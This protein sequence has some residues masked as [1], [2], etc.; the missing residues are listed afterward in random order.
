MQIEAWG[1]F[2]EGRNNLFQN[3]ALRS[4]ADKHGR[5]IAQ[6]VLHW[7]IHRGIVAI[8]ESVRRERMAENLNIF[9]FELDAEDD[10]A[11]AALDQKASSFF[12]HRDPEK[13]QWLGTRKL[14]Q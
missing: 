7:L 1:P 9:D 14:Q 5:T 11:I 6:I 12:D 8:P 4:I 13:V 3:Q 2:P 10:K